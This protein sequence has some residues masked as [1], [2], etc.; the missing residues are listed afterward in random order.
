[1]IRRHVR[2]AGRAARKLGPV[3]LR[4]GDDPIDSP[5]VRSYPTRWAAVAAY[6]VTARELERYGQTLEASLHYAA[7]REDL[8][9]YPDYVLSIGPRGGIRVDRA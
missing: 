2:R 6:T 7:T 5:R 9:E 8:D 4:V 1:M 3:W